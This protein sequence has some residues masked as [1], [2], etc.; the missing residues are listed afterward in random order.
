MIEMKLTPLKLKNLVKTAKDLGVKRFKFDN[1]EIEFW[2]QE[3]PAAFVPVADGQPLASS[4]VDMPTEDE[5]LY[6]SSP[7]FDV[8]RAQRQEAKKAV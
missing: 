2:E 4:D 8:I 5:M 1:L 6:A 7:Y 3:G